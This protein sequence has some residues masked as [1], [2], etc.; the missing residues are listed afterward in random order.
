MS[1]TGPVP[2]T[3]VDGGLSLRIRVTPKSSIEA[4]TGLC[5]TPEGPAIQVK[6][7]AVPADGAANAAVEK[8]VAKWLGLPKS[9]VNLHS[10]SKSRVKLLLV[11]GEPST[12]GQIAGTKLQCLRG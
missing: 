3:L 7:R 8:L 2:W 1:I 10:G 6:V 5:T 4:V 12:L 9:V 11:L